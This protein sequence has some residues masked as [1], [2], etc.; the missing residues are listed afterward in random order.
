[1][2]SCRD[3]TCCTVPTLMMS[4]QLTIGTKLVGTISVFVCLNMKELMALIYK[5][6]FLLGLL[7]FYVGMV[8]NIHSD[9]ILRNLR[10]PGEAIYM[11]PT[12]RK[13]LNHT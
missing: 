1:M 8:V 10:K 6:D 3:T 7:L 5:L 9:Y 12:G 13:Q 4:G 2:V 11:I